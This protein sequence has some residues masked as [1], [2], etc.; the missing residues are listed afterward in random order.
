M[1]NK[2]KLDLVSFI[3]PGYLAGEVFRGKKFPKKPLSI[4]TSADGWRNFIILTVL[5]LLI[6]FIVNGV[7]QTFVMLET[8]LVDIPIVL[9]LAIV[10]Y[11]V[12]KRRRL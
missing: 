6:G 5:A 11:V 3:D 10:V 8:H 12:Q 2:K 4:L 7:G 9:I 1:K